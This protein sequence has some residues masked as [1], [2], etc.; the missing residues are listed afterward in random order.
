MSEKYIFF[1]DIKKR[2]FFFDRFV[3]EKE[4]NFLVSNRW[5]LSDNQMRF[6]H[7]TQFFTISNAT[8]SI[9]LICFF[10]GDQSLSLQRNKFTFRIYFS[11]FHLCRR[12]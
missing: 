11:L 8:S 7:K 10:I 12:F 6:H 2:P 3:F 1:V 4:Y 9:D 5:N